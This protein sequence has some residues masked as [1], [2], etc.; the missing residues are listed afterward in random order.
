MVLFENNR[1]EIA[2]HTGENNR[3]L[4]SNKQTCNQIKK[5]LLCHKTIVTKFVEIDH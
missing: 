3:I 4:L 1:R 5:D 2:G